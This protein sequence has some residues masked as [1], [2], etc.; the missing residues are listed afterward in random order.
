MSDLDT[1]DLTAEKSLWDVYKKARWISHTRFN[2]IATVLLGGILIV[3]FFLNP[4]E[5]KKAVAMVRELAKTGFEV[6][7]NV[8]GFLL[9]GYTVFTSVCKVELFVEMA[10]HKKDGYEFS[11]LKYNMFLFMNTF[12]SFMVFSFYCLLIMLL[13]HEKGFLTTC[14]N[15]MFYKEFYKMVVAHIGLFTIGIGLFYI[16]LTMKSLI[17]NIY[18]TVMTS[19]RWEAENQNKPQ[20]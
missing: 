10:R 19:I 18:H 9:A 2:T 13:C 4:F 12:V 20:I 1:K 16:M 14:V 5:T 6:S 11:H 15:Y 7:L 3:G 17:F 8:L